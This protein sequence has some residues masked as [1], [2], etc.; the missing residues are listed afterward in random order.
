MASGFK[1]WTADWERATT[2]CSEEEGSRDA[3]KDLLTRNRSPNLFG[4]IKVKTW[5]Q[6]SAGKKYLS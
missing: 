3:L 5:C 2:E 6:I 4:G 1:S